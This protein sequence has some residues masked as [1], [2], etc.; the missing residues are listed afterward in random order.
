MLGVIRLFVLVLFLGLAMGLVMKRVSFLLVER[1][2]GAELARKYTN[3]PWYTSLWMGLNALCWLLI[4]AAGGVSL[5]TIEAAL[6]VS[7]CV[8]LAAIDA[9]IKKLPNELLL[10][11]FAVHAVAL[12]A[13][14]EFSAVPS[15]LL[16]AAVGF[17]LFLLPAMMGKG[18]GFGDV[19]FAAAAG[20]ILAASDFLVSIVLMAL[21][22]LAY[23]AYLLI[24]RKGGLK[25]KVALGPFL[26]AGLIAVLLFKAGMA[27]SPFGYL[28]TML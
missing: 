1:R 27:Q 4:W 26:A 21:L 17:G 28:I 12:A 18:A 24:S 9:M 8:A 11:L 6:I 7:V 2:A 20:F 16:G 22:L 15:C 25:S 3:G 19:K 10:A 13:S 5:F 23:T 14:R